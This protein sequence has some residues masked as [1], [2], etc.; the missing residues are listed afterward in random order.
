MNRPTK[1]WCKPVYSP[2]PSTT[3][4]IRQKTLLPPPPPQM[5]QAEWDLVLFHQWRRP[6]PVPDPPLFSPAATT[7]TT[8]TTKYHSSSDV[9]V[10]P[11]PTPIF[12]TQQNPAFGT[13]EEVGD[14]HMTWRE[15]FFMES[16]GRAQWLFKKDKH[17]GNDFCSWDQ[18]QLPDQQVYRRPKRYVH[19]FSAEIDQYIMDQEL[20]RTSRQ[21]Q[22][23]NGVDS[24]IHDVHVV[25][26]DREKQKEKEVEEEEEHQEG[27]EKEEKEKKVFVYVENNVIV[28]EIE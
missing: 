4:P 27:E 28:T 19:E 25:T 3:T 9:I 16:Y 21:P 26:S 18:I 8:S 2:P 20:Q 1:W 12:T 11:S 7:T 14:S 22:K 5:S 17:Y 23:S 15:P 10:R 6:L 13:L 24:G